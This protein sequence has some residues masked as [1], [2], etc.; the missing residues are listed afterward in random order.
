MAQILS[1]HMRK[2]AALTY[3]LHDRKRDVL[4]KATIWVRSMIRV[5]WIGLMTLIIATRMMIM[6]YTQY[7]L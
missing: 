1:L 3:T 2:T 6:I 7:Y 4:M 5:S